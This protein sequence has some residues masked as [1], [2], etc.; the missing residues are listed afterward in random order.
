MNRLVT[1]KACVQVTAVEGRG[2]DA[3]KG[4]ARKARTAERPEYSNLAGS[5]GAFL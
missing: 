5:D 3:R 4:K 2:G 1:D